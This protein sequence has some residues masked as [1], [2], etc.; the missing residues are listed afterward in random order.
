M[1]SA[2]I[3]ETGQSYGPL[4]PATGVHILRAA[5]F[6]FFL[7]FQSVYVNSFAVLYPENVWKDG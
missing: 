7:F 6:L 4:T 2:A 5:S 1:K 3:V